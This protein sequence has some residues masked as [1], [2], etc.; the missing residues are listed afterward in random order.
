[1]LYESR[2]AQTPEGI[3]I[4]FCLICYRVVPIWSENI[5]HVKNFIK[6]WLQKGQRVHVTVQTAIH[7]LP[8]SVRFVTRGNLF[9]VDSKSLC[10]FVVWKILL[11]L[12]E[13]NFI[14]LMLLISI[15]NKSKYVFLYFF[16]V[17]L[18][19]KQRRNKK[20]KKKIRSKGVIANK[21]YALS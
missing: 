4:L 16:Y 18:F 14:C 10:L 17:Y 2:C 5:K 11:Y 19:S 21:N 13:V 6:K 20:I 12:F 15:K 8:R 3:V 9:V 7:N 1:M